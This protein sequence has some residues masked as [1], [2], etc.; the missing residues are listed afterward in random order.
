MKRQ[1][2]RINHALATIYMHK[3]RE[4]NVDYDRLMDSMKYDGIKPNPSHLR[5]TIMAMQIYGLIAIINGQVYLTMRGLS[6]LNDKTNILQE[7]L[8]HWLIIRLNAA[9]KDTHNF[10]ESLVRKA[11]APYTDSTTEAARVM[12]TEDMCTL[13]LKR[14]KH[15][16]VIDYA[17]DKVWIIYK[18]PKIFKT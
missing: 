3:S 10:F 2:E 16:G 1:Y 8:Y 12:E 14:L 9:R 7:T 11:I 17:C 15:L 18:D 6:R 4:V 5:R 13:M